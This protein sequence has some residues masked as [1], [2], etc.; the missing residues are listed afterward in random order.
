M[1]EELNALSDGLL[2]VSDLILK[3]LQK[4]ISEEEQRMLNE[5][6]GK[7][8][9]NKQLF[10]ELVNN[11]SLK[12]KMGRFYDSRST[13]EEL[14]DLTY[15]RIFSANAMKPAAPN[16]R[17]DIKRLLVAASLIAFVSLAAYFILVEKSHKQGG[18]VKAKSAIVA[19]DAEPGKFKAKLILADGSSIVLDS[20]AKGKLADQG[21]TSV[22]N[23]DGKL[24]YDQKGK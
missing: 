15:Q 4:D 11:D 3:H 24:V 1:A 14:K 19:D 5:W 21:G 8:E 12:S 2:D 16:R 22:I 7:S 13:T 18:T 6:I 20:A 17:I 10:D 9:K 23:V